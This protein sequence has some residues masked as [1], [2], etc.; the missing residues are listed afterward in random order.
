[1]NLPDDFEDLVADD[2][3]SETQKDEWEFF[4]NAYCNDDELN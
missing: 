3:Y 2:F 1:M 4:K